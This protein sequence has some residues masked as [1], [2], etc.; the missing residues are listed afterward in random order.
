[1]VGSCQISTLLM[2][3][4]G[5]GLAINVAA[6]SNTPATRPV[7]DAIPQDFA[8]ICEIGLSEGGRQLFYEQLARAEQALA[9]GQGETAADAMTRAG[10][11]VYGEP[12][13]KCLGEPTYRRWFDTKVALWRLGLDAGDTDYGAIQTA[14]RY[15]L[16]ALDRDSDAVVAAVTKEPAK[17]FKTS[18]RNVEMV[19]ERI[20]YH[21]RIGAF[22]LPEEARI[23][24][25]CRSAL[26]K[27]RDYAAQQ[28]ETALQAEAVA[29]KRPATEFEQQGM[30]SL[31]AV[32]QI[33]Q[34]MAGVDMSDPDADAAMLVTL[35]NRD[36]RD[37]LRIARDHEL[38]PPPTPGKDAS[39]LRAEQRG[40]EL[41]ARANDTAR[42]LRYR[43]SVYELAADY[44]SWCECD[45][46]QAN[47]ESARAAI[48][49]ALAAEEAD[50]EAKLEAA[51]DRLR[52]DAEQAMQDMQ[53]TEAQK[54]SF[55]EEAE[56]MEAELGF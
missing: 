4:A 44:F 25:N 37:Q 35:Q 17:R 14:N 40:D 5:L 7:G 47:A 52:Q 29:F 38:D 20:D 22:L 27:L 32:G 48:Q 12:G 9:A 24:A 28:I 11:Q 50:R 36:S 8:E 33:S 15:A 13:I 31:N 26:A 2:A 49:P 54:K 41:L 3:I 56:A 21:R 6:Q 34:A 42:S 53:K 55:Q 18:Y 19:A 23:E 39:G 45:A 43:D 51:T 10:Q 46:K 16:I 1:M 30:Q